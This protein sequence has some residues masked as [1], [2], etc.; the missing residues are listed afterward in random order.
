MGH[1]VRKLKRDNSGP[2]QSP[3]SEIQILPL[4]FYAPPRLQ[5]KAN[6]DKVADEHPIPVPSHADLE[7]LTELH[8]RATRRVN[9]Y[10]GIVNEV[11]Q[12]LQGA[13]LAMDQELG[14]PQPHIANILRN[15]EIR[16]QLLVD[17]MLAL[18]NA[19]IVD[20]ALER[21]IWSQIG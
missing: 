6:K 2:H 15:I 17:E 16:M 9:A 5:K 7:P 8:L 21:D 11:A 19:E 4:I 20:R 10:G 1:D 18:C 3:K 13:Q 12:L 14:L